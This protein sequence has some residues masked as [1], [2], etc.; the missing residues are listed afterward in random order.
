MLADRTLTHWRVNRAVEYV[1]VCVC[2]FASVGRTGMMQYEAAH[3]VQERVCASVCVSTC[4]DLY[5]DMRRAA[6]ICAHTSI[7]INDIIIKF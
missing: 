3:V 4:C 1:G 6:L 7:D 2:L 5:T